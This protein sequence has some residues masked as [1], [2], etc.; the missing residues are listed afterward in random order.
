MAMQKTEALQGTHERR[1]QVCVIGSGPGGAVVAKELAMRG[2]DVIVLEAGPRLKASES[3]RDIGEFM[4]RFLSESGANA[5]VGNAFVTMLQAECVGGTS[6]INSAIFKR[7]PERILK[8]WIEDRQLKDLTVDEMDEHYE[9]LEEEMGMEPSQMPTQ[10]EKNLLLKRGFERLGWD[11][12]PLQRVVKGC[13]G[14]SDCFTGCPTGVKQTMASTYILRAV[15]NG[16]DLYP[17]CRA[18]HLRIEKGRACG[19]E[20]DILHPETRKPQGR[21]IVHADAV[22]CSGGVF[23]S[24]L[25]LQRAKI[26]NARIGKNLRAHLGVMAM[27][28]FDQA[29]YPWYGAIQGWGSNLMEKRGLVMETL[30]APPAVF[31]G[32]L[33]GVGHELQERIKNFKHCTTIAT[34]ARGCSTG[35]VREGTGGK[36]MPFFWIRQEDVDET[37]FGLKS[38]IDALF[39]SGAR[40]VYAGC[41]GVP[42]VMRDPS[43]SELLLTKRFRP[44][45]FQFVATHLFGTCAM[46]GDP[47]QSVVD[48]WCESHDIR[49]LYVC[50]A[51]I[52]PTGTVSNPQETIMAFSRRAALEMAER[53]AA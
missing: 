7:L 52:L 36:P 5:A 27:G 26:R 38:C 33:P 11:S 9:V 24:P 16:A 15:T 35:L 32:R 37:A 46:G 19:V 50:D 44:T 14:A 21:L 6:E 40:E 30:W 29:V 41:H 2:V 13:K 47:R 17:L 25:L 53:Y 4:Q 49:D 43:Q 48:S 23:W 51:S 3:T 10:G 39:A 22:V 31:A 34:K 28:F 45:S 18:T 12:H 1:T 8:E 20:A 42:K